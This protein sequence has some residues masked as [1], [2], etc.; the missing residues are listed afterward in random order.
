MNLDNTTVV[1]QKPHR[2]VTIDPRS[3]VS[4]SYWYVDGQAVPRGEIGRQHLAAAQQEDIANGYS[5]EYEDL[6]GAGMRG[7]E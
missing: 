6:V 1:Q 3:D 4:P 5:M 7:G 2:R